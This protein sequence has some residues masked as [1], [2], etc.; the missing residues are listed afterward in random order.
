MQGRGIVQLQLSKIEIYIYILILMS[1]VQ[2][3]LPPLEVEN[4]KCNIIKHT[5]AIL[6]VSSSVLIFKH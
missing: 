3:L 2:F 5:T 4:V 1:F 6:I